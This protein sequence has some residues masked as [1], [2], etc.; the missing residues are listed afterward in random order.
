[1][2]ASRRRRLRLSSTT[3]DA[4]SEGA[5]PGS[6]AGSL[7]GEPP[8]N[9]GA[10]GD[11]DASINQLLVEL[12]QRMSDL[13]GEIKLAQ[14][15]GQSAERLERQAANLSQQCTFVEH[16]MES[17]A[18]YWTA[19]GTWRVE[20][21]SIVCD[22]AKAGQGPSLLVE[23]AVHRS[24]DAANEAQRDGWVIYRTLED[25]KR[26]HHSLKDASHHLPRAWKPRLRSGDGDRGTWPE[27]K[28]S[29]QQLV[30]AVMSDVVLQESQALYS[31]LRRGSQMAWQGQPQARGRSE[32]PFSA[33]FY[34]GPA[35]MEPGPAE[36]DV[37]AGE[38][39][40][41]PV[42]GMAMILGVDRFMSEC[43]SLTN[44]I[45]NAVATVVVSRWE[46]A[47]DYERLDSALN[48]HALPAAAA[49]AHVVDSEVSVTAT[50]RP[51]A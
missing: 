7:S 2:S 19:V 22:K 5:G 12:R 15:E 9:G 21:R 30:D 17:V 42:A 51:L 32:D 20:V 14:M 40:E 18:N 46:N 25:F 36:T 11:E 45:G 1:L 50:A 27:L 26:L 3:T 28:A 44:F 48:G 8:A 29:L 34:D 23:I 47:L 41:V 37:S 13:A 39:A 31:F 4:D 16:H 33:A 38:D 35:R 24:T 6:L 43:R 49:V 10:D